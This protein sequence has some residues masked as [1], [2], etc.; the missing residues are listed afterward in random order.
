MPTLA[1]DVVKLIQDVKIAIQHLNDSPDSNVEIQTYVLNLKTSLETSAEAG[2]KLDLFL[3]KVGA[4]TSLAQ[5]LSLNFK[6]AKGDAKEKVEGTVDESLT[7]AGQAIDVA[8]REAARGISGFALSSSTI[9]L[10]FVISATGAVSFSD[11]GAT[12]S[13]S[14]TNTII[15]TLAAKDRPKI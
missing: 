14:N 2:A 3:I 15:L 5:T 9:E 4:K 7:R 13:A 12:V 8:V 10:Q 6:L 11:F 1:A